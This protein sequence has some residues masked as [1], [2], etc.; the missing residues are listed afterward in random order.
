MPPLHLPLTDSRFSLNA[1]G[2]AG[3]FGG[4]ESVSAMALIPLYQGRRWLGWY[5]SPGS[6]D[7]ARR[8]G[9]LARSHF[10]QRLFPHTTESPATLFGFDGKVGPKYT[11]ALSGTEMRT[12]HL[13]YL[14]KEHC[15][16]FTEVIQVPGRITSPAHVALIDLGD[17]DYDHNVPRLSGLNA[18]LALIPIVVSITTCVMCALVYDWYNFSVILLGIIASG[19]ASM[20]IGLG[21]LTLESVQEPAPGSPRGEGILVPEIW[22]DIVVVVKGPEYAVNAI[23]KGKFGF[24]LRGKLS[25]HAIGICSILLI[26]EFLAQLLLV[27]QGTLFGQV[28]FVSSLCISWVYTFYVSSFRRESLLADLLFQKLG[29][30]RL[31]KFHLGTRTTMAA[32]IAFLVFHQ[33]PNPTHVSIQKILA[34]LIPNDTVVWNKWRKKVAQQVCNTSLLCLE[35]GEGGDDADLTESERKLLTTL[36]SDA[37]VAYEGYLQWAATP[38]RT[39][40]LQGHHGLGI[41]ASMFGQSDQPLDRSRKTLHEA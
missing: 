28:M 41:V 16:E 6:L 15:K 32:F 10:W 36:V 27:P 38:P 23:T 34:T 35:V 13:G 22:E 26:L 40:S 21:G 39:P 37:K 7:V 9:R 20:V 12:A 3:I 24:E 4:E 17:V 5:N 18:F 25:Y 14:A 1:W 31:C 19:S 29:D 33:L 8:F 30:P 11:A 2:V